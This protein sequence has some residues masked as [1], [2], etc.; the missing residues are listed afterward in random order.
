MNTFKQC[1]RC[2][3]T[4]RVQGVFYRASTQAEAESLGITGY[5]RNLVDGQVEVL[6]CGPDN[7]LQALKS[8]LWQGPRHSEVT[9][10]QCESIYPESFPQGFVTK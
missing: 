9:H 4:G 7:A 10:V 2:H 6:A 3:V 1:I 8:W 5:A